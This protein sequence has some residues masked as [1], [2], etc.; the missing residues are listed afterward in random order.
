MAGLPIEDRYYEATLPDGSI[1][2]TRTKY[3]INA[4]QF[5]RQKCIDIIN[6]SQNTLQKTPRL[7]MVSSY[8]EA[9]EK[10]NKI[11]DTKT[12]ELKAKQ[13]LEKLDKALNSIIEKHK[14]S[15]GI[16]PEQMS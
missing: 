7:M 3:V 11:A 16:T 2:F 13:L 4:I 9:M 5:Y 14:P 8:E 15:S 10:M 6:Q 12:R 1:V